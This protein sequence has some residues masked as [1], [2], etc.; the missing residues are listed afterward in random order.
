MNLRIRQDYDK[1]N[2]HIKSDYKKYIILMII[3]L[4][5]IVVGGIY[6]N[7][8][9]NNLDTMPKITELISNI[10]DETINSKWNLINQYLYEDLKKIILLTIISSSMIGIPI[11]VFYDMYMGVTLSFTAASII[12]TYGTLKGNIISLLLLFMPNV[13]LL[14]TLLLLTISSAKLVEN[15]FKMKKSLKIEM[16]RHL[17]V[18]LLGF[19][20][21]FS[22]FL[23]RIFS[24]NLMANMPV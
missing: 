21:I 18:C 10:V 12:Y 20:I 23:C 4:I 8:A 16:I 22:G 5:G 9:K 3:F 11:L 1:I 13:S 14:C 19:F 17:L 15:I 2:A 7:S 24:I 6:F